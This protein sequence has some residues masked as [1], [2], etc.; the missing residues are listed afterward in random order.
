MKSMIR[1]VVKNAA[2]FRMPTRVPIA[3]LFNIGVETNDSNRTSQALV[4][5][6]DDDPHY[7]IISDPSGDPESPAIVTITGQYPFGVAGGYSIGLR[8]Y[9]FLVSEVIRFNSVVVISGA[10]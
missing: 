4:T 3:T 1:N 7:E 9:H 2:R 8:S 10:I 6:G 5:D